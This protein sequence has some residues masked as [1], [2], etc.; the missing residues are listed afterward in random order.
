MMPW[1]MELMIRDWH[2]R[3]KYIDHPD[4]ETAIAECRRGPFTSDSSIL[5]PA[6][7]NVWFC[8]A[9]TPQEAISKL[10]TRMGM[11]E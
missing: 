6:D 10:M 3:A 7:D 4:D 8:F 1:D 2:F 9:D 5:E 11:I